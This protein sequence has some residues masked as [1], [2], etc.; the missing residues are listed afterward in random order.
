MLVSRHYLTGTKAQTLQPE[1]RSGR[2]V[3]E[4]EHEEVRFVVKA[5]AA[6]HPNGNA[7]G[8]STKS[9]NADGRLGVEAEK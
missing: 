2:L 5:A 6:L 8:G 1:T 3:A 7:L 4:S 9:E